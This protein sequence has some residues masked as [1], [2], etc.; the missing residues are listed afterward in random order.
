MYKRKI[1]LILMF[2]TAV[3]GMISC[4]KKADE[5]TKNKNVTYKKIVILDPAVV[6]MVY[7]LESEDKI[8]AIALTQTSTIWPEDKTKNLPSV[9]AFSKPSLEK[10]ISYK[11]DLVVLSYAS[12]GLGKD[13]ETHGIKSV[14]FQANSFD[15]IFSNFM[16]VGKLVGK[17]NEATK[18]I[19]EKKQSLEKMKEMGPIN[20]KGAFIYSTSPMMAFGDKS[21]PGEIL[22]IFGVQNLTADLNGDRPILTPEYILKEN[23]DFLLGGMGI[24]S[25][26]EILNANPQVKE[27]NAAKNKSIIIVNSSVLLRGSPR[28][29]DETV[30]LYDEI[31]KLK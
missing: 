22:K 6:E 8:A 21:L 18:I 9:G 30:K 28:I 4:S 15:E 17:E 14:V 10:I 2:L 11:P 1:C 16:E 3:F 19:A 26:E 25:A 27:T 12:A 20:K 5:K 23:P 13:L 7:L 29:V 31:K 24:K